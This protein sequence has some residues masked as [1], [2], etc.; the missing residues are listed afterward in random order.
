MVQEI[1]Q[2]VQAI[3]IASDPSQVSLHQQALDY[4]STIQQNVEMT[5]RWAL[6][7]FVEPDA[8]GGGRK[9]PVQARFW[10]LRLLDEFLDKG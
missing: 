8:E 2:I 9:Y 6:A 5:W 7:I 10:A 4:L 3:A 1:D